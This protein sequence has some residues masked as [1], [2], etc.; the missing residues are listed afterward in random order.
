MNASEGTLLISETDVREIFS[1]DIGYTIHI[2]E[3]SLKNHLENRVIFPD[4][5]SVIFDN[6][7]QNRINCM[8]AALLDENIY[9]VKWVSVFPQNPQTGY[10]NVGGIAVI[11]ELS[12]GQTIA[13]LDAGYLT[14]VRTA[15]V[16]ATACKYLARDDSCSI[17]FIGAGQQA[18][19]HL[20][21]IT[22]EKPHIK[23]CYVSSRTNASVNS[24][25]L[26]E[27]VT[28]PDI[29]FI[30]CGNDYKKAVVDSDIIITAISGQ[31]DILKAEWI[32]SGAL[33]IHVGGYED[34]YAVAQLADK[35]V[36]DDWNSVKHRTQTLSRMYSEGL[37]RDDDIYG[38]LEDIISNN[39][40]ARVS[41]R[42]FIYFCSVGLAY[43]DVSFAYY[44]Y[45]KCRALGIGSWFSF[46]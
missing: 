26:E 29:E 22:A 37:I 42:E 15:A 6:N 9:G 45:N 41:P 11:S 43:I 38:N 36:C 19:R 35:I 33:Y 27:K 24:F 40:P 21:I 25:I 17:G 12:H 28:H 8:P 34:E 3:K 39:K 16:G 20:D 32:K 14:S 46:G 13:I 44:I 1:Q 30:D 18:R 4:K 2:V 31:A 23:K 5:I 7:S 10:R